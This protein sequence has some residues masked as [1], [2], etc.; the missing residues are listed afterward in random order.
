MYNAINSRQVSGVYSLYLLLRKLGV[1]GLVATSTTICY[2][3]TA[4]DAILYDLK[5]LGYD[6]SYKGKLTTIERLDS[7]VPNIVT[8]YD[9]YDPYE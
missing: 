7:A 5:F 2:R 6:E 8:M 4:Y 9:Y 1:I 3:D